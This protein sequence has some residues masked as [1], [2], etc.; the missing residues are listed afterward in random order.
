MTN[1]DPA[2]IAIKVWRA[3]TGK[4]QIDLAEQLEISETTLC[5]IEAGRYEPGAALKVRI[6]DVTGIDWDACPPAIDP[7]EAETADLPAGAAR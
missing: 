1:P 2:N 4:K 3:R 7:R 5:N 6:K